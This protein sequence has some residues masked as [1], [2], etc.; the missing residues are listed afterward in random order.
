MAEKY[1]D[2]GLDLKKYLSGDMDV[3]ALPTIEHAK[4]K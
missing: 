3:E 2:L 4:E 1:K